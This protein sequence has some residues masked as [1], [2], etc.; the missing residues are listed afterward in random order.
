MDGT[1][2]VESEVGRGTSLKLSFPARDDLSS[3]AVAS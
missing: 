1:I 3:Q 2:S